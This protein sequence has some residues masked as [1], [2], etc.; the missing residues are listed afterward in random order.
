M[1]TD[2]ACDPC[3]LHFLKYL[4]NERNASSHTCG[5]YAR[6]ILQFSRFRWGADRPPPFDWRDADSFAARKFVIAFQKADY[7]PTST[8]RKISALRAFYRFLVREGHASVNPFSGVR[9]PKRGRNLPAFLSVAEVERLLQAPAAVH[10]KLPGE[11]G[12][13]PLSVYLARRD[14]ALLEVLY[15]TG[16]RVSEVTGLTQGALDLLGGVA[17]VRGKGKKERLCPLGGPACKAVRA[18]QQAAAACWPAGTAPTG[19][20]APVFRNREGRG[21]TPRSVERIM[22][23]YLLAAG[24]NA[25]LTPHALRHS[26]ATHM[27]DAGADLRSVQ[28]LLGHASLSTT[29]IYTHVTVERLRQVY[30]EAHPRA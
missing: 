5:N 13:R 28:E 25:A 29:Q 23:K 8:A 9:A 3:L 10:R 16:A 14:E 30:A 2:G 21:M 15:S 4:Q 20:D 7:A 24:L 27:L 6:D 22:K 17:T 12:R 1:A 26:F 11:R 18:M 19:R